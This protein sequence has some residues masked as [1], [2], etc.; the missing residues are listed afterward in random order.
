[1]ECRKSSEIASKSDQSPTAP[2]RARA[3]YYK[4]ACKIGL[5]FIQQTSS[6]EKFRD[7]PAFDVVSS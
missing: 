3:P 1:M 4:R 7:R 2:A 5:K 6:L